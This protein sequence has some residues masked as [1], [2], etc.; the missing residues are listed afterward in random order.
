MSRVSHAD[1]A[2]SSV[3]RLRVMASEARPPTTLRSAAQQS[4]GWPAFAGHDTK[5]VH[6]KSLT[7]SQCPL[8]VNINSNLPGCTYSL[9]SRWTPQVDLPRWRLPVEP[10][11]LAEEM[12]GVLPQQLPPPV[13]PEARPL[14]DVRHRVRKLALRMRIIRGVHQHVVAQK[15]RDMFEHVLAL[16][17]LDAAEEPAAFHVFAR[18]HLQWRGAADIDRLLVHAPG[19][20]TAT[21]R[22]RIPARPSAASGNGR[23]RRRR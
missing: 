5:A 19:P 13:G 22:S 2:R 20:R 17:V 9:L 16:M 7:V 8:A 10:L 11:R 12:A 18:L 23:T 1:I 15:L 4:R 21:S 3:H 6:A 14:Q